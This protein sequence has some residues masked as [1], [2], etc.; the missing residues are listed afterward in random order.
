MKVPAPA[1]NTPPVPE[2]R[3]QDP[4][5]CSPVIKLNKSMVAELVSQIVVAPSVPAIG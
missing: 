1:L 2:V 3:V 5:V 4:P